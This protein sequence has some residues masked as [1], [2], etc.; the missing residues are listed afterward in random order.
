MMPYGTPAVYP[1]DSNAAL[2]NPCSEPYRQYMLPLQYTC[3]Q[4]MLPYVTPVVHPAECMLLYSPPVVHP[5][6]STHH[7]V[8]H[9]VTP[10]TSMLT[11]LDTAY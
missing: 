6:D 8:C 1:A 3:R 9:L 10:V 2:C 7:P 11:F 4:Y 5:A